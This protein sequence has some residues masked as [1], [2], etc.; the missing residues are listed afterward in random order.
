[1]NKSYQKLLHLYSRSGFGV[2]RHQADQL[3]KAKEFVSPLLEFSSLQPLKVDIPPMEEMMPTNDEMKMMS[4]QDRRE[5]RKMATK[6]TNEVMFSWLEQMVEGECDLAEKMALFWH[7]HFACR[8]KNPYAAIQYT[9]HLRLNGLGDFKTLLLGVAQSSAMINYLHLKQNKKK[10][11]NEDF[12]REL[13]ELFT[14]GRDNAYTEQDVKEI[15]RCFTGWVSD[16]KMQ[17]KIVSKRHDEGEKTVF[18]KAGNFEGDDVIDMILEK[19]ECAQFLSGKIYKY[20]VNPQLNEKRVTEIADQLYQ[21]N[22]HIGETMR[23]IFSASWFY[24]E[25]NIGAKIK[26]PIELI[27]TLKKQFNLSPKNRKVWMILQRNLDQILYNPPNVAGWPGDKNWIDAS[28]LAQRMRLPSILLNNG[29][30]PLAYKED[31]DQDPSEDK[32]KSKQFRKFQCSIDWNKVQIENY[33]DSKCT[34]EEL[35]IRGEISREGKDF[36]NNNPLSDYKEKVI[37]ILSLPE[38]QLC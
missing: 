29:E 1:M 21:S 35:L 12:A 32:R 33:P 8:I 10:S 34:L 20:F 38:Y 24:Q 4:S 3:Q 22:Y 16:K 26:S 30:I 9:D 17:F 7:G 37:Q 36:L 2:S 11:P 18:G 5:K 6:Y 15:A 27:V 31:Y 28:R 14:L 19:K 13:C 23:Y 25:E